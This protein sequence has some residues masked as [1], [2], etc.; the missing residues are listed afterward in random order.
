MPEL[1]EE[2]KIFTRDESRVHIR[3]RLWSNYN[4][5]KYEMTSY[6]LI[7]VPDYNLI[8]NDPFGVVW[9]NYSASLNKMAD[10]WC[11]E[12]TK[13]L[14]ALWREEAVQHELN[15]MHNKKLVWDKISQG[16]ADGGYSRSA[17]QCHVRICNLKQK[18]LQDSRRQ[19]KFWKP[20]TRMG[21]IWPCSS[22]KTNL[23][24]NSGR[25]LD[26]NPA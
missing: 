7:T 15:T 20:T 26:G 19:K 10:S 14:I 18:K 23:Q 5:I 11:F 12:E 1:L 2:I 9:S 4:R 21:D 24:T 8:T 6:Q 25:W 13:L 3:P 16:M 17:Q 22:L